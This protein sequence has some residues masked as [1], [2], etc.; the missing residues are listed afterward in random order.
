MNVA[1][2]DIG[3]NTVL[4]LIAKVDTKTRTFVPLKNIYRIPRLSQ[5]LELNHKIRQ[6]K[7]FLLRDIILE[8]KK[9]AN[10]FNCEHIILTATNAFRV[11]KNAGEIISQIYKETGLTIDV[12][13]G[14]HEAYLSYLGAISTLPIKDEQFV[15]DIGGGS[16]EF[17][18]GNE[19]EIIYR[20]SF[21]RGAVNLTEIHFNTFP[22]DE[23]D[24]D[25]IIHD[26][27]SVFSPVKKFNGIKSPLIAVAGTPTSLACIKSGLNDYDEK[28]IE[29]SELYREE[30]ADIIKLLSGMKP[31]E[32]YK[33]FGKVV[34][35]REDVL[36]AG[37]LILLNI[38]DFLNHDKIIVSGKGLRYGAITEFIATKI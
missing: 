11:A 13:T 4:L 16:T 19:K 36:L 10:Y 12:V 1:S 3:S 27:R 38:I 32:I 6:D 25:N 24:I 31:D 17:I 5:G 20:N 30:L 34:E 26:I 7:Y 22:V 37:S 23:N 9:N 14:E 15:L 29:G 21:P 18:H 8:Y 35:G 2:I 33:M 28:L